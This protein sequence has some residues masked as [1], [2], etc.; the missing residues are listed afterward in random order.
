VEGKL[1]NNALTSEK[2]EIYALKTCIYG[3]EKGK[4]TDCILDSPDIVRVTTLRTRKRLRMMGEKTF[5]T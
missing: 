4:N 3:P 5:R 1:P 2:D